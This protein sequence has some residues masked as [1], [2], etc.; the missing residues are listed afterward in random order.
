MRETG[1]RVRRSGRQCC[2]SRGS[3]LCPQQRACGLI[4]RCGRSTHEAASC[5]H[6]Q[7][8]PGSKSSTSRGGGRA[9]R[10]SSVRDGGTNPSTPRRC[11]AASTADP[12]SGSLNTTF[13]TSA[14]NRS[15]T[16]GCR[17]RIM[18]SESSLPNTQVCWC[19]THC[20]DPVR[21]N[22]GS[23]AAFRAQHC[24]D[25]VPRSQCHTSNSR[26]PRERRDPPQDRAGPP[27]AGLPKISLFFFPRPPQFSS[28]SFGGSFR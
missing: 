21:P 13:E 20:R 11:L 15:A 10:H 4:Q 3:T 18:C 8:Q 25:R 28:S 14:T 24:T 12:Q 23:V 2:S 17:W 26:D 27:S 5:C 9:P 22:R 19:V 1:S 6:P 7:R 16:P